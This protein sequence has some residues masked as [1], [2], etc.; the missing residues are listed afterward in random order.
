MPNKFSSFSPSGRKELLEKLTKS[1]FMVED[2]KTRITSR[3][4][5]LGT[6]SRECEDGL[7]IHRTQLK[8]AEDELKLKQAELDNAVKPDFEADKKTINDELAKIDAE[9]TKETAARDTA[10]KEADD[11]A[12]ELLQLNTKKNAELS[13]ESAQ[14]T[15]AYNEKLSTKLKIEADISA[16]NREITTKKNIKD[17]CPTCGQKLPNVHKPDTS[18]LEAKVKQLNEDLKPAIE[19]VNKV[20]K[21]HN[22]FVAEINGEFATDM[23]R[24]TNEVTA[25]RAKQNAAQ[26]NLNTL[27]TSQTTFKQKLTELTLKEE[28]WDKYISGLNKS[29]E[30]LNSKI[31]QLN[32]MINILDS[33][34]QEVQ[35]HINVVRKMDTLVKRDFRGYLLSNIISYID[36]KAKDYSDIVFGTRE[37]NVYLDGN[38]LDIYYCNKLIDN[39][40][41]GEKQRVDLILQFALRDLLNAYFNLGSNILVLDEITDFLDAKSCAA[42]MH[43]IEQELNSTE[44]VFIVSHHADTLDIP[45]DSEIQ[46]IKNENGISE[47]Y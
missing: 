12:G 6:K 42:V 26:R 20:S 29:I 28:N 41:G 24:L 44:S 43:L 18:E 39:L 22:E 19:A 14:Y 15:A 17:V 37:L 33:G 13:N 11:K 40:S 10:Q 35:E 16:L 27:L 36:T 25:A 47:V 1:D 30:Q 32:N 31:G 46:I 34:W 2:L 8:P 21:K 38:A 45:A 4:T 7:L 9:I 5:E 3:L 23:T